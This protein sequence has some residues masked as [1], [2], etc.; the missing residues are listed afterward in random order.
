MV[1]LAAVCRG[2]ESRRA[3]EARVSVKKNFYSDNVSGAAP[4]I[5]EA[6]VAANAGDSAPYG[7]DP[8]TERLPERFAELFETE[9]E[10]YP[11]GTG[12]AAN[13]LCA[14][15]IAAPFLP[16]GMDGWD[17]TG[18]I[19]FESIIKDNAGSSKGRR[20]SINSLSR[21]SSFALSARRP[22]LYFTMRWRSKRFTVAAWGWT[23][24]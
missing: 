11:V 8:C 24:I 10:V 9:V 19:S 6:I 12:T 1:D 23:S 14:S 3:K 16:R 20:E 2:I 15:I 5:L 22:R 13:G 4:E 18:A 17:S 7:A 21:L